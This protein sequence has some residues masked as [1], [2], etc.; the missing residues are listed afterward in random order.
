MPVPEPPP[1]GNTGPRAVARQIIDNIRGL[2]ED[3]GTAKERRDII[4]DELARTYSRMRLRLDRFDRLFVVAG[5]P[6][7]REYQQVATLIAAA[8]QKAGVPSRAART[9]GSIENVSL[10]AARLADVALVQSNIAVRA[11]RRAR[12][13]LPAPPCRMRALASLFPEQVHVV[14]SRGARVAGLTD[15]RGK[16][17]DVGLPNSGTRIDAEALLTAAGLT[18]ADLGE[19]SG[20]GVADGLDALRRNELDA[21]IATISA[22]ARRLQEMAAAGELRLLSLSEMEQARL[23]NANTGFVAAVLPAGSYP[24]QTEPVRTVAVAALLATRADLPG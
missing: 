21:V 7:A 5:G 3:A 2:F 23:A 18:L 24:G 15:L 20:R 19:V 14:V 4:T 10:L 13:R 6:E 11:Q 1:E 22:P 16:R 17:V 12:H 9:D 8:L